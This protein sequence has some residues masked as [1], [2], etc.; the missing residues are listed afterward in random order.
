MSKRKPAQIHGVLVIDKPLGLTSRAVVNKIAWLLGD[1]RCGH[2]GTLDPQASGVLLIAFGEAT[3]CVRWL[4]EAEKTYETT[5]HF[6][7]ATDSDDA[8]GQIVAHL[9]IPAYDREIIAAALPK[10]GW[11]QQIPPAV[12]ALQKDGVRD[13]ERVRRGEIIDRPARE[14]WLSDVQALDLTSVT[15]NLRVSCGAGFYVRSLA[16]DLGQA[17]G[18]LGHVGALRRTTAGGLGLEIAHVLPEIEALP[19]EQRRELLLP[20]EEVLRA[21]L[22]HLAVDDA[23]ALQLRQ[24]KLPDIVGELQM[25]SAVP[26][27][28]PAHAASEPPGI[29]ILDQAGHAV[30]LAQDVEGQLKVLR[31]FVDH[32]PLQVPTDEVQADVAE[33]A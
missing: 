31:G 18:T 25:P 8:A 27:P 3:K 29:L 15:V 9:P 6:G 17:L 7:Q 33:S 28:P 11:I 1:K 24:G 14:V 16:R 26:R 13:Y 22:P 12:S 20:I 30:C 19:L 23:T 21:L 5:I 32:Q 2:A 4:M 10:P